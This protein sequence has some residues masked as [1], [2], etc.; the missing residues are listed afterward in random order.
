MLG[1]L[2]EEL[3]PFV[4]RRRELGEV[5]NLLINTRVL[6]LIGTGGVGKTRLALAVAAD[7]QRAFPDGVWF[8]AL[9][10][11][12]EET[13]LVT[14]V[15]GVLGRW[16][17]TREG[18]LAESLAQSLREKHLLLI[19]DN[20]EH[21]IDGVAHLVDAIARACPKVRI[22]ATS[23]MP[24]RAAGEVTYQVPPLWMPQ[25]SAAGPEQDL[26]ASDAVRFFVDRARAVLPEFELTPAE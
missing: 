25:L 3:T 23:R 26:D 5:R 24:L 15:S 10:G 6:T 2:P 14:R 20:C 18:D 16:H 22:L 8:A 17:D 9:D 21:L 19:L 4:G 13:L 1:N 12:E 11:I 7:R